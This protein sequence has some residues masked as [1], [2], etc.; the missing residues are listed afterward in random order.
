MKDF[1]IYEEVDGEQARGKTFLTCR[2]LTVRKPDGSVRARCVAREFAKGK[3]RT[4]LFAP[5]TTA[6]TARVIDIIAAKRRTHTLTGD[7]SNAFFHAEEDEEVY[8]QPPQEWTNADEKRY[9]KVWRLK[10]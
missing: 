1:D 9:G 5:S 4:D 3:K 6:I 10:K 8:C 2:W 7:I